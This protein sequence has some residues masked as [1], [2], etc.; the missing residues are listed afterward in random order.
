[1]QLACVLHALQHGLLLGACEEPFKNAKY[2]NPGFPLF[3]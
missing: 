3:L 1:M 2:C